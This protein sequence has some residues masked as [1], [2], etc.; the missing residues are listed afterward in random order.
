MVLSCLLFLL[1][2]QP[3]ITA[4]PQSERAV[5]DQDVAV[6]REVLRAGLIPPPDVGDPPSDRTDMPVRPVVSRTLRICAAS[7]SSDDV[8]CIPT[9]ALSAILADVGSRDMES[10]KN[11]TGMSRAIPQEKILAINFD[12]IFGN[13]HTWTA[14]WSR[15]PVRPLPECA[16]FST[17]SYSDREA[18][19]YVNR[20]WK[21][22]VYGWYV[23]LHANA[24]GGVVSSKKLI[25][26]SH[27]GY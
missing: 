6:F 23:R 18:A 16:Q 11:G 5:S 25:W 7:D 21:G 24:A 9:G 19:V 12:Q 1:L 10:F 8:M 22:R 15:S 17:P 27:P 20:V 14:V 13:D 26:R 3:R 4:L 2:L